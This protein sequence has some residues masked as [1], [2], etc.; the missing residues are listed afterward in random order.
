MRLERK[1]E[2]KGARNRRCRDDREQECVRD[3]GDEIDG[4]DGWGVVLMTIMIEWRLLTAY[5]RSGWG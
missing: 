1:R 2:C 3:D 4:G 5:S